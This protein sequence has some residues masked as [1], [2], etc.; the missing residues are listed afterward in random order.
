MK[1]LGVRSIGGA[2]GMRAAEAD[3]LGEAADPAVGAACGASTGRRYSYI[4]SRPPSR[5]KPLSR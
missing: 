3:G 2:A 1:S 5:P 4:P